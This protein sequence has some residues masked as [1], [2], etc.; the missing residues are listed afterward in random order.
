[1]STIPPNMYAQ[2]AYGVGKHRVSGVVIDRETVEDLFGDVYI[3]F[4]VMTRRL[5]VVAFKWLVE[6]AGI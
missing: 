1:M 4:H 5:Q 6:D 3:V 2:T